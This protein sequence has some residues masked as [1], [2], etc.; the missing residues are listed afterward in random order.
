[1]TELKFWENPYIIKDNKEDGHNTVLPRATV[2]DAVDG[3]DAPLRFTL[4]GN[5]KFYWQQGVDDLR[6]ETRNVGGD[7]ECVNA[8]AADAHCHRC[9]HTNEN[10]S[11][12]ARGTAFAPSLESDHSAEYNGKHKFYNK[13]CEACASQTIEPFHK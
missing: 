1:M 7:A 4:N 12:E 2:K 9:A 5:W 10:M 11:S 3:T 6:T 8:I 13:C